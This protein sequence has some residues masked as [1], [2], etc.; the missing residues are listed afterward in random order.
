MK[1]ELKQNIIRMF[2]CLSV[3]DNHS[4][5]YYDFGSS[6][7]PIFVNATSQEFFKRIFFKLSTNVYLDSRRE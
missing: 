2:L 4:Q 5:R 1:T 6:V 7:C 3:R